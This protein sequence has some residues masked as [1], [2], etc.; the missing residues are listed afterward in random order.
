[1]KKRVIYPG[2]SSYYNK[3]WLGIFYP[4][5]MPSREWFAYYCEHF[6]TYELNSTFYTP[7]T[8]K[9]LRN[10]FNK[11]PDD[12][13]FSAKAPKAITHLKK[14]VDCEAE[15][16]AFYQACREGLHHKI[17]CV[18]FQTPPSFDYSPERL[19]LITSLLNPD[20]KNVIEFR[21]ES[22]WTQAVFDAFIKHKLI[23]CSVNYPKLPTTIIATAATGYV[24]LHGNPKLFYS[25]YSAADLDNMYSAIRDAKKMKEVFVYFNNTASTAGI[26]NALAIQQ[27]F[28]ASPL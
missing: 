15:L 28:L 16:A 8:A 25:E 6:S 13:I 27:R 19:A 10:W 1:M 11:T 2:C 3:K 22:W 5:G 26:L 24:R 12:F 14:F 23:F 20:F 18:L 7:P 17:G 21:N 4:E 9:S